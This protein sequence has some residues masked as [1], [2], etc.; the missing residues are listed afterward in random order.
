[1]RALRFLL[2]STICF[3]FLPKLIAEKPFDF[4]STPGKLPKQ[5]VPQEYAIR[6]VPDLAKLT[7]AG[8]ETVKLDVR[9]PVRELILNALELQII[10]ASIDNKPLSISAIKL[11]PK[12][13]TLTIALPAALGGGNHAL[14]LSF[15]GKINQQ[16]QGLFYA[17]YQEQGS[18][19]QKLMLGTQFEATDARRLFPCWDEPSFRA[20]FQLTAVVPENFLAVSNMPVERE[21]KVNGAKEV[22]FAMTPSMASYLNVFVA[23]ELDLI[24]SKSGDTQVRVIATKNKAEMGRYALEATAQI[25]QYYNDYFGVPYPLPKLD[26]IAIPGGFGGAMENWGGITYYESVL[27][28]DPEK[29]SDATRQRIYEV[30]AHETAH[31]WFGD[32]VTMAWWDNLWLNEGF[33]SWMGSKCSAHFNPQ[34]EIWLQKEQPRDPSRRVG[35]AKETAMEG[36]VLSTTHPIQQKISNEAEANSAF[37]DITYKKGQS[38]IRMLESF[39]GEDVFREGIRKYITAHKYSNSTTADLWSALADASG[40]PVGE[41][42]ANWTEQPGFPIVTVTRKDGAKAALAQERFTVHFQKAPAPEWKI[43]LTYSLAGNPPASLLMTNRTAEL[44]DVPLD[45]ALKLNIDGAGNY[46]VQYDAGSWK[47]LLEK[48]PTLRAPDRVNLLSD[49][50]AIVQANR[51]PLSLY[52][53]LIEKL[54][55]TAELAEREQIMNAFDYINR[56]IAGGDKRASFQRYAR[57]ILRPIFDQVGWEPKK[58][59]QAKSATLRADLINALGDLGDQ[60]I[61]AGCRERFQKFLANPVS[62]PPDLRPPIFNVVGR[63]A[64]DATWAKLHELGLKT[65]SIE[66]K[67]NYYNALAHATHPKLIKRALQ[68]A[69]TEELP[70]SRALYMVPRVARESEHPEIAWQFAQAHMKA[71][72][73]KADALGVNRYAPSLFTFFSETGRIGELQAYAKKNLPSGSAKAVAQAIDEIGFR[74]EFKQRLLPQLIAWTTKNESNSSTPVPAKVA[75]SLSDR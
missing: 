51:A 18:G 59:E 49:S 56:L 54:P 41:V 48:L 44:P 67:Q 11:D 33:A 30:I 60:E 53:G 62:M 15:T 37:D 14:A 71:L 46:R 74:S 8:S 58:G 40:K 24:E 57:S 25:L 26:Q 61:V 70:T 10:S 38:F 75:A 31:Q 36:D 42:A 20:R 5:V 34:W 43:P 12:Q 7:F 55:P 39:L 23:G 45:R 29:S 27:L 64:D 32:L 4:A 22:Q 21:N 69:L 28:F 50:W 13:E 52:F 47:L 73:A 66:E 65:T 72:L 17:R 1:M 16:G 19:A 2:L 35:I 63:Y 68:I 9:Q 3:I 6:I